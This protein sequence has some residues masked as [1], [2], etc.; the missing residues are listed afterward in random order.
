MRR[1]RAVNAVVLLGG[2]PG[3]VTGA[4]RA[5]RTDGTRPDR[6]R[7]HSVTARSMRGSDPCRRRSRDR[8]EA[9]RI[10]HAVCVAMAAMMAGM[11]HGSGDS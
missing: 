9:M 3:A 7:G 11:G 1:R 8:H 5:A 6:R 10:A 2:S 4:L